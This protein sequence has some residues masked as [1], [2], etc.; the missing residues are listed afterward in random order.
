MAAPPPGPVPAMIPCQSFQILLPPGAFPHTSTPKRILGHI[1][2]SSSSLLASAGMFALVSRLSAAAPQTRLDPRVRAKLQ[3]LL[4]EGILRRTTLQSLRHSAPIFPVSKGSD[5]IRVI[6]DL[7]ELNTVTE[8]TRVFRLFG[9][10]R[11]LATL[12]AGDWMT[13]IDLRSGYSQVP[14]REQDR[15]LLG[16]VT[17]EGEAFC[18]TGLPFDDFLL[19]SARKEH[20]AWATHEA[21]EL[22]RSLGLIPGL[23]KC[24]LQPTRCLEYLGLLIN[25]ENTSV[26]LSSDK[27]R[28]YQQTLISALESDSISAVDYS[29]IL[30]RLSFFASAAHAAQLKL[31]PLQARQPRGRVPLDA[32]LKQ[33]LA[34][35]VSLL[36]QRPAKS[37]IELRAL[38]DMTGS[39]EMTVASDASSFGWGPEYTSERT[40]D[41]RMGTSPRT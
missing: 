38:W 4:N 9:I 13:K 21:L 12:T 25:T 2:I 29:K 3:Q 26:R 15:T 28:K 1:Y 31:R 7:R 34:Q 22:M 39:L 17:P 20:L 32:A 10:K 35:W 24:I 41:R 5:D 14:V 36:Q 30:G 37:F 16:V 18:Y 23:D 11:A 33:E 40:T 19:S 6:H 27:A 8:E